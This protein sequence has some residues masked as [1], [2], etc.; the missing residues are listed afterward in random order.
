MARYR[1]EQPLDSSAWSDFAEGGLRVV[2]GHDQYA[3]SLEA[4]YGLPI[5]TGH[6]VEASPTGKLAA[7][8]DYE[9]LEGAWLNVTF[10]SGLPVDE[11]G[12]LL[13]LANL[14]YSFGR[15]PTLSAEMCKALPGLAVCDDGGS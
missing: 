5:W 15:S 8:L 4:L 6:G 13:A 12:S 1:S 7:A 11:A 2:H 10:G 9:V 3:V 14:R